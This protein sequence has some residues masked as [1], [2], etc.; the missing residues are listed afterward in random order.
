L[1]NLKALDKFVT[2][3]GKLTE[4]TIILVMTIKTVKLRKQMKFGKNFKRKL[5]QRKSIFKERR[6]KEKYSHTLIL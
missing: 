5:K 2:I 1:G 4:E 6:S 3:F